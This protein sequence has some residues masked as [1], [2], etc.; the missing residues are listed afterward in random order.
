MI[1]EEVARD[2]MALLVTAAAMLVEDTQ[3]ELLKTPASAAAATVWAATLTTLGLDLGA[4]GA[5]AF[6]LAR[7]SAVSVL[8]DGAMLNGV[9]YQVVAQ[10]EEPS[11]GSRRLCTC[12]T[13]FPVAASLHAVGHAHRPGDVE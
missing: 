2:G 8:D 3:P 10:A 12:F 1:D 11:S 13:G 4:L 6:V 7:R 9:L 5:A